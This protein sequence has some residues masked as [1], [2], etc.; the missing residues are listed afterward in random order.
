MVVGICHIGVV[1]HDN[2]SLKGKRKVL[3]RVLEGVK[4]RFNVSISE[5]G[6]QD[7]WQRAEIGFSAVGSSRQVVNATIDKVISFIEGMHL[8]DIVEQEVE[9]INCPLIKGRYHI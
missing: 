2:H 3:K 8:V 5:V 6:S 4:N 1:I 7:M 9:F